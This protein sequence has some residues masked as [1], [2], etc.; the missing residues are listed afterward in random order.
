MRVKTLAA[1][2]FPPLNPILS[3]LGYLQPSKR[4]TKHLQH[5][6]CVSVSSV[7]A[8]LSCRTSSDQMGNCLSPQLVK[9][10]QSKECA[11]M[12]QQSKVKLILCN[13]KLQEFSRPVRA[14][15]ILSQ[16]PNCFLCCSES[17][18]IGSAVP[19]VHEDEELQVGQIY[20]L[21]PLSMSRS[22]L[23]LQEMCALAIKASA[24]LIGSH[25]S[26]L[27]GKGGLLDQ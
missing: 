19:P 20:F 17:M 1:I 22:P 14:S 3:P 4:N 21:M 15:E 26:D 7:S 11:R 23:S 25:G 2:F 18:L 9:M 16:R 8:S 10:S 6:L 24:A 12:Q 13:G 27:Q 5:S